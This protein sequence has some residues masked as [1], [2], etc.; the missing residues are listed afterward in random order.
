M[1]PREVALLQQ[2]A[3]GTAPADDTW[4]QVSVNSMITSAANTGKAADHERSLR[5]IEPI[6]QEVALLL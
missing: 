3:T 4:R 5:G 6:Q 1:G 2:R